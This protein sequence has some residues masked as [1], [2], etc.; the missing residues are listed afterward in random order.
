MKVRTCPLPVL[1]PIPQPKPRPI[2]GNLNDVD[3]D[4]GVFGLAELAKEYGPLFRLE[5][6]GNNLLIVTSQEL[7]NE[8]C[9]ETRFDKKL[10]RALLQ[11]RD[12][13][14]TGCSRPTPTSRT[15]A[16]HTGS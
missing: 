6:L 7:V 8:L 16:R 13:A 1:Q 2:V 3:Q 11:V 10:N 5:V 14:V 15:G 4:K 12:F 9:D